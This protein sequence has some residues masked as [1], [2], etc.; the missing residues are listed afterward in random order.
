MATAKANET[1]LREAV[2]AL[3]EHLLEGSHRPSSIRMGS[4]T[5]GKADPGSDKLALNVIR[6]SDDKNDP[7][8]RDSLKSSEESKEPESKIGIENGKGKAPDG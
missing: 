1:E 7:N 2:Q 8:S 4:S 5:L 6:E 3:D